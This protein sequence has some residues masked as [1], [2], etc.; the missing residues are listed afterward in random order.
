MTH[1]E[2]A[3]RWY[4]LGQ[5][6][7]RAFYEIVRGDYPDLTWPKT[8]HALRASLGTGIRAARHTPAALV[9]PAP[10]PKVVEFPGQKRK[11]LEDLELD[12]RKRWDAE[13]ERMTGLGRW[14]RLLYV[15]DQHRP[16]HIPEALDLSLQIA[17]DFKPDV[18]PGLTDFFDFKPYRRSSEGSAI[19]EE[20]WP[21]GL[22][23]AIESHGQWMRDAKSAAPNALH[24]SILGNHDH[25]L[26]QFLGEKARGSADY[27]LK[28]FVRELVEQ[29]LIWMGS[30]LDEVELSPGMMM[31][32]GK[33]ATKNVH[34]SL[35]NTL[36]LYGFQS[37][38]VMGHGHREEVVMHKGKNYNTTAAMSGC[39]CS[40]KAHY[41]RHRTKWTH[42]IVLGFYDPVGYG[43]QLYNVSFQRIGQVMVAHYGDKEYR[44]KLT[45]HS[46]GALALAA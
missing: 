22:D 30:E 39:T 31:L 26:W 46:Y 45:G 12:G 14:L 9:A 17:Q 29:G 37:S 35:M 43:A 21:N 16:Y 36:D 23:D 32:H 44:Q 4:D 25:W 38:V 27:T 3:Q 8:V 15:S 41:S 20:L 42:G 7:T 6:S 2:L 11:T 34:T 5:I 40:L 18:M 10:D 1:P 33:F 13:R 24:V 28:N 19:F